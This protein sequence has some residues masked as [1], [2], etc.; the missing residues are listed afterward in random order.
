MKNIFFSAFFATSA[1]LAVVAAPIE[2]FATNGHLFLREESAA[3][4]DEL[5]GPLTGLGGYHIAHR[6]IDSTDGELAY[7]GSIAAEATEDLMLREVEDAAKSKKKK[8]KSKAKKVAPQSDVKVN[9][10]NAATTAAAADT[11]SDLASDASTAV[12]D[13][14]LR[15]VEEGLKKKKKAAKPAPP[16]D[17]EQ[18]ESETPVADAA[19]AAE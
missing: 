7:E 6:S 18:P 3:H 13:I 12:D 11:S 19:A 14:A 5:L 16:S 1:T 8:K 9:D 4:T 10:T 15:D 17:D 2:S